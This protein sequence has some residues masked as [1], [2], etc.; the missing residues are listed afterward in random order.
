MVTIPK[1]EMCIHKKGK[2]KKLDVYCDAFPEGIPNEHCF[3]TDVEK[4]K[5]C[6]DGI[7]FEKSPEWEGW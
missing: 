4:L 5:E 6:K 1:C 3:K 7:R 2:N